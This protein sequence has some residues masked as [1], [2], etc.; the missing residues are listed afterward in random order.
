MAKSFHIRN[1]TAAEVPMMLDWARQ[2][3]WNPGLQDAECFYQA[4]TNGFFIGLL[5]DEP[6]VTG[7]AVAYD[8]HFAFCGLYIVK[9]AYRGQ[10]YGIQLTRQRL[11]YTG[12]RITGLDGVLTMTDKY[13]N[14]GY[15]SAYKN[16]RYEY[17]GDC[18][19]SLNPKI[20]T[21]QTVAFNNILN[22]DRRYFPAP[23]PAF[24]RCW[25][26]QQHAYSLGYIEA[27]ELLG[28]G[29]IRKC[30]QGY[31]IGPLFAAT[32]PIAQ[33]LFEALCNTVKSGPIYLDIPMIN[34]QAQLLTAHY[35]MTP[36]FEVIRM[37]RNGNPNND[38]QGVYGITTFE[39]G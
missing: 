36:S 37:Y 32:L 1:M 15:V 7:A 22:F 35:T 39:L 34:P 31:K 26:N 30:Y 4:D 28:Y 13:A 21:L 20:V 18:A 8:E 33:A 24:L 38:V 5:D 6:I 9:P 17:H 3:G 23:R 2:E 12:K 19:F 16:C 29:V 10:G 27:G 14:L 11:N 25:I